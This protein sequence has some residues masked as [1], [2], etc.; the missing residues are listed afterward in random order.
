M[1]DSVAEGKSF[2]F[3]LGR[4]RFFG[5]VFDEPSICGCVPPLF[6]GAVVAGCQ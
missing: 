2:F 1:C 4:P 6:S 5:V 3:S